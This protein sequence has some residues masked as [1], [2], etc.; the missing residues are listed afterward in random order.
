[1]SHVYLCASVCLISGYIFLCLLR[2][3][4]AILCSLH[5]RVSVVLSLSVLVS[6]FLFFIPVSLSEGRSSSQALREEKEAPP[7]NPP[8]ARKGRFQVGA[9]E[10]IS[11]LPLISLNLHCSSDRKLISPT[12]S[13]IRWHPFPSPLPHQLMGACTG[14][15]DASLSARP[16]PGRRKGTLTAPRCLP[17][18]RGKGGNLEQRREREMSIRGPQQ[19]LTCL[20]GM[21]TAT[22]PWPAAMTTM[23]IM[24]VRWWMKTWEKN[25][26]R[27]ERSKS[28]RAKLNL[29]F[30][31]FP[32]MVVSCLY[33]T[34]F[35]P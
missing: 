22:P 16:R 23:M 9:T 21:G 7:L 15:W 10:Q 4:L 33:N 12:S 8:H 18:W 28:K 24:S 6:H 19:W 20:E 1:M 26:T 34:F 35:Y 14:K 3:F 11:S 29:H 27:S 13:A 2:S 17:T 5:T 30:A 31:I 32:F 25:Y